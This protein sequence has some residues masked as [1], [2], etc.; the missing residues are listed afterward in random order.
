MYIVGARF[1]ETISQSFRDMQVSGVKVNN[2]EASGR[3]YG[4]S[5]GHWNPAE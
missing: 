3:E 4:N 2:G 1:R 5:N